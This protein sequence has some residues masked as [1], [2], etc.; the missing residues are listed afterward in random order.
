MTLCL[1]IRPM[2]MQ[3]NWWTL[4]HFIKISW[5]SD[6]DFDLKTP[7]LLSDLCTRRTFQNTSCMWDLFGR[8]RNGINWW[9]D[10]QTYYAIPVFPHKMTNHL[11]FRMRASINSYVYNFNTA[12][13]CSISTSENH[14]ICIIYK[15]RL[16]VLK[17]SSLHK[18]F[19]LSAD[20]S[21][22]FT[23]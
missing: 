1:L 11:D 4:L 5:N 14:S 3:V 7:G 22:F 20:Y 17:L 6:L 15:I 19:I 21:N 23:R 18:F 16:F 9:T 8:Q 2:H 12:Q 13:K 10:W